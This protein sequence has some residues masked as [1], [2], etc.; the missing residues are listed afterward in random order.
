MTHGGHPPSKLD[1]TMESKPACS[2]AE[3]SSG[4]VAEPMVL[5]FRLRHSSNISEGGI[6]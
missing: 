2:S 6:P 4:V 1:A 5:I 3:A